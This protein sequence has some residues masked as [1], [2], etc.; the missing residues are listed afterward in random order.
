[1]IRK[2]I[3]FV[4]FAFLAGPV[5]ASEPA[6]EGQSDKAPKVAVE[7]KAPKARLTTAERWRGKPYVGANAFD[8]IRSHA[9][10]KALPP[11]NPVF[12]GGTGLT[13]F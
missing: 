13:P 8:P 10:D 2:S 5:F 4:A 9:L 1:M 6:S 11:A 12:Q 3:L 7:Q